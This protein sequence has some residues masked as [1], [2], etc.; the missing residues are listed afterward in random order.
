MSKKPEKM[1]TKKMARMR[2][3]V[4]AIEYERWASGVD[5]LD[6]K[7]KESRVD[8]TTAWLII[9]RDNAIKHRNQWKAQLLRRDK[10][11]KELEQAANGNLVRMK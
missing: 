2:F 9:Q 7:I 6:R 1:S 4:A 3:E 11:M 5:E 10:E 8:T